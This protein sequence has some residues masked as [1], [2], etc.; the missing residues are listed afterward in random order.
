ME[1]KRVFIFKIK[2]NGSLKGRGE[3]SFC[4]FA[5]T[6][7]LWGSKSVLW[8]HKLHPIFYQRSKGAD[9]E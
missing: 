5:A 1:Y 6:V 4:S 9:S 8:P 2:C 7:Y 3:R